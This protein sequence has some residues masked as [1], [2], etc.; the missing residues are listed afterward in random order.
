MADTPANDDPACFWQADVDEAADRL[1]AWLEDWGTDVLVAY[2]E[3][4]NYGHPTT[5]R[6][7]VSACGPPR[8]RV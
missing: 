1:A 4:G 5:S 7:T 3:K 8:K 6:S 2:D